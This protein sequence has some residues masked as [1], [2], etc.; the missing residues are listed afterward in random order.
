MCCD[1]WLLL[2]KRMLWTFSR[3]IILNSHPVRSSA[4]IFTLL[5]LLAQAR[6]SVQFLVLS[7]LFFRCFERRV[8]RCCGA[9]FNCLICKQT[10]L[11]MICDKVI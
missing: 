9:G 2:M 6:L 3:R 7:L 11:F 8:P 1:A 10:A 4:R 5:H